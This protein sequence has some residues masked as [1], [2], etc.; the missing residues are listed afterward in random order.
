MF[1]FVQL[2]RPFLFQRAPFQPIVVLSLL[3]SLQFPFSSLQNIRLHHRKPSWQQI[4]LL[5]FHPTQKINEL[6]AP[7]FSA[8][9]N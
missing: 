4:E 3:S 7:Y 9:K 8:K 5:P 6:A 1:T 2:F